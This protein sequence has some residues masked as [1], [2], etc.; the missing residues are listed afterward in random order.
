MS[1]FLGFLAFLALIAVA[2]YFKAKRRANSMPRIRLSKEVQ[3]RST[4]IKEAPVLTQGSIPSSEWNP[5]LDELRQLP[6][7]A[8]TAGL[9]AAL[10]CLA[11]ELYREAEK[12]VKALGVSDP[13]FADC[14]FDLKLVGVFDKTVDFTKDF[15]LASLFVDA[16][17]FKAIGKTPTEPTPADM[18]AGL[19]HRF[20]GVRKYAI[21]R[22]YLPVRDPGA[23]LF[24]Q[25]FAKAKGNGLNQA[26]VDRGVLAALYTRQSGA[27]A[28]ET[29][30][31]GRVPTTEEF[32]AFE[33]AI[34]TMGS[35]ELVSKSKSI[36]E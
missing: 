36:Q 7:T 28:A 32:D 20:R 21:A 12:S 10:P 8:I 29:A 19:T 1:G 5:A 14:I 13:S 9:I 26:D 30:L 22:K 27:W 15:N 3:K 4:D 11:K 17:V 6:Q 24:G 23:L 33:K 18:N 34:A 2:G 16:M 25:E 35:A 31:T